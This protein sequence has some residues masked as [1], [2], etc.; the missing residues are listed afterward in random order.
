MVDAVD[1][2]QLLE[3]IIGW[4]RWNTHLGDYQTLG[5][6]QHAVECYMRWRGG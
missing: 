5:A 2:A 4:W 3:A 6:A 1:S